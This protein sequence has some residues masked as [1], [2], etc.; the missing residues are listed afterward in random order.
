MA[1]KTV[2]AA[3]IVL[4]INVPEVLATPINIQQYGTDEAVECDPV[5]IAE[6]M[7]GVDGK[8]S[9]GLLPAITPM[10]ITLQAD[11]DSISLFETWDA[12]QKANGNSLIYATNAVYIHPSTK[13][14]YNLT[15]GA[16]KNMQRV[17]GAKKI[18]QQVTFL[19]HWEGFQVSPYA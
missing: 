12:T 5:D 4:T 11:S 1:N 8:M 9:A 6:T 10:K 7:M 2:T 15:K 14:I 13:K 3:N 18:L 17:P 19:I 16:L